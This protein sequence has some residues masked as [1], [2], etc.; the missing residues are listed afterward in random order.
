M[1]TSNPLTI[2]SPIQIST[3]PKSKSRSSS[4]SI[5]SLYEIEYVP[6]DQLPETTFPLINPYEYFSRKPNTFSV[7]GVRE[8][9]RPSSSRRILEYVS[10]SKF[11]SCQVP[12]TEEEQFVSLNIPENLPRLWQQQG[13]TH[14]H[15]GVVRLGLTLH[16]RKGLPVIAR[17]ALVDSR[18]KS[19][20]QAC[21]GTV[22][23]TLN[24]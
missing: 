6:G 7:K 18:L 11:S 24:A 9:I 17:L 21:I 4:S 16:A 23:T 2:D 14:L 13:Y 22:Q 15:F 12:A 20:Q 5:N 10:S 1:S 8:L 3:L 19:Y